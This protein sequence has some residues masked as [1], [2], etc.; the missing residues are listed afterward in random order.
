MD[1]TKFFGL[2]VIAAL[3]GGNHGC[4]KSGSGGAGAS[5]ATGGATASGGVTSQAG[6]S[7]SVGTVANGGATGPEAGSAGTTSTGGVTGSGGSSAAADA[8]V[9]GSTG[10]GGTVASGGSR[11]ATDAAAGNSAGTGG[12]STGM[13]GTVASGGSR[14]ASDAAAGNATR[15]DGASGGATG[16]TGGSAGASSVDGGTSSGAW[17]MGYYA[18]WDPDQ[19][20][21][22]EIE[23]SGLTHIAMAFYLPNQDGSMTLAGG[24]PQLATNLI[25]AAHA[26]GVKAIASIGGADSQSG[27]Q[28]ATA[29]GT[30]ATFAAN[31]VSLLTT[32]GY[33]GIDIDSKTRLV[34]RT[35]IGSLAVAR[36]GRTCGALPSETD[37]VPEKAPA[38][39]I[40]WRERGGTGRNSG[41]TAL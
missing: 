21:I 31:L 35:T 15:T 2:L 12:R 41:A 16:A 4:G 34:D 29:S 20:P 1:R 27:F 37:L 23:W 7:G 19:Y 3:V 24:N 14:S 18:S 26:N 33:D 8:A 25:A 5:I 28:K 40:A 39:S 9:G 36:S 30:V 22:S 17:S 10:V 11:G 32:T 6:E 38:C 13:G